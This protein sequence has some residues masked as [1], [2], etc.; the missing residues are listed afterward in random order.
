[1]SPSKTFLAVFAVL[2]FVS[3][4]LGMLVDVDGPYGP[5]C[6]DR[7]TFPYV[8]CE[9]QCAPY[10][11]NVHRLCQTKQQ[12]GCLYRK[13]SQNNFQCSLTPE[14]AAASECPNGD[15]QVRTVTLRPNFPV[16]FDL[17]VNVP[18]V[19]LDVVLLLDA[20]ES[21]RARLNAV[22][23]ELLSFV[24]Q[25]EG[26]AH[27]GVAIYGGEQS[28][29]EKGIQVL[30]AAKEDVQSALTALENIPTFP[31]SPRTTLTALHSVQNSGAALSLRRWRTI[32][33]L[34]GNTPG[35]EP[36]C[37]ALFDRNSI[38]ISLYSNSDG[39]SVIPANL[40]EPGLDAILPPMQQCS[41][42]FGP[43]EPQA[44]EAGQ[45]SKIAEKTQGEVINSV[46]ADVLID[47]VDRVRRRPNRTHQRKAG[48]QISIS[49]A[50][51]EPVNRPYYPRRERVI[52]CEDKVIVSST[53]VPQFVSEP[54]RIT[55]K[56][57]LELPTGICQRGPFSCT[58]RVIDQVQGHEVMSHWS[59]PIV[60]EKKISI[61]AC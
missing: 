27:I 10:S 6:R 9:P 14:T 7:R 16:E 29:D 23:S 61:Q 45:A 44:V 43:S 5:K 28:F 42:G 34:V 36:E 22:K 48:A 1:M 26:T 35:R 21:A 19:D 12:F 55:G 53:G 25:L 47:A 51:V 4:S 20:S 31:D 41:N 13:C 15:I 39:I 24:R 18:A 11:E 56:V 30:S 37:G 3:R 38:P 54:S 40:G 60:N 17:S 8:S 50:S 33:V 32:V 2:A 57:K 49:T 59:Q 46:R 58:I 52:G